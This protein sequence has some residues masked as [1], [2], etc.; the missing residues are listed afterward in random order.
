MRLSAATLLRGSSRPLS[1]DALYRILF[2]RTFARRSIPTRET[3][4]AARALRR[5]RFLGRRRRFQ[6]SFSVD[7][8]QIK[9]IV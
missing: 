2:I 1:R 8:L 3:T 4:M 5:V 6:H 7:G 9:T